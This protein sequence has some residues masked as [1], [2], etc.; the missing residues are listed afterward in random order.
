MS[1]IEGGHESKD[2]ELTNFAWKLQEG[3]YATE[4][5][6]VERSKNKNAL[7]LK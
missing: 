1:G 4:M 7:D 3:E 6:R 2:N 5:L